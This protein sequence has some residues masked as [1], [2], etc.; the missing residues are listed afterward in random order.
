MK[1]PVGR[2]NSLSVVVADQIA[3][4]I[5][6]GTWKKLLP[7]TRA[8]AERYS[9]S[10]KTTLAAVDLL[11]TQGMFHPSETGKR[12][13]IRRPKKNL[14]Q[15]Q[16]KSQGTL[17]LLYDQVQSESSRHDS[18]V[19]VCRSVWNEAGGDVY[20]HKVDYDRFKRPRAL[21]ADLVEKH[22]IA[23]IVLLS[24]RREWILAAADLR[25][26]YSMGGYWVPEFMGASAHGFNIS[27]H[28]AQL[29]VHLH[30]HGHRRILTPN[31]R[32][33]QRSD[34]FLDS[35]KIGIEKANSTGGYLKN[36]QIDTPKCTSHNPEQ[37]FRFWQESLRTYEPTAVIA[38][39]SIQMQSLYGFCAASKISIPHD[40]SVVCSEYSERSNWMWPRPTMLR[41]SE[42]SVRRQ[43]R[44]WITG[45]LR[46]TG[47]KELQLELVVGS[48]VNTLSVPQ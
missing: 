7:G 12:R 45:G 24:P 29:I 42:T 14:E 44:K 28:F 40:L 3:A 34:A 16:S 21:L 10:R 48:S 6:A 38:S 31:Y 4:D 11:E 25:P 37:W 19:T 32:E 26:T 30:A 8:L 41:H 36:L 20:V 22:K 15:S 35:V 47:M 23:A 1:Q 5:R 27:D 33:G 43:L 2:P 17:L 13:R 46:P 9:V 39:R 18:N